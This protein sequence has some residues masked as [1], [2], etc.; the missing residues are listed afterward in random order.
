MLKKKTHAHAHSRRSC[1]YTVPIMMHYKN[2]EEPLEAIFEV[3]TFG[4][5]VL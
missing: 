1:G 3:F 4:Q 2:V 5:T